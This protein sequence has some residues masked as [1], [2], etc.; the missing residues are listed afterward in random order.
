MDWALHVDP[1]PD[2]AR[3][4]IND[5][6]EYVYEEYI[7]SGLDAAV[8]L[9][10][11]IR[12]AKEKFKTPSIL[13]TATEKDLLTEDGEGY[14]DNKLVGDFFFHQRRASLPALSKEF[15]FVVVSYFGNGPGPPPCDGK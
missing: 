12:E 13:R 10:L 5:A 2:W 1:D 4:T 14:G 7:S 9:V 6:G 11:K 8:F 3:V 15:V